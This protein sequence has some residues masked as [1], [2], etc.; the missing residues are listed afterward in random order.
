[1]KLIAALVILFGM[2]HANSLGIVQKVFGIVKVK[3]ASSI[4]K[5]KVKS[6][7]E[8]KKGD[9]ISTYRNANAVLALNDGS[10]IVLAERATIA[11]LDDDSISQNTGK[12]Y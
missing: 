1:M 8:I 6:G 4:K 12:I 10:H 7:Y 2:L 3:S 11:F 9:I 5:T